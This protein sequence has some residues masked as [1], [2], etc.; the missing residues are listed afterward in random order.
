MENACRIRF[1][2][3]IYGEFGTINFHFIFHFSFFIWPKCTVINSNQANVHFNPERARYDVIAARISIIGKLAI[4]CARA[5]AKRSSCFFFCFQKQRSRRGG[6]FLPF[7]YTYLTVSANYAIFNVRTDIPHGDDV[8]QTGGITE[9]YPMMAR[10]DNYS[11]PIHY[12]IF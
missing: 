4:L 9:M 6:V 7:L 5:P 8:I 11:S 1:T 2:G 12:S 3:P 10:C